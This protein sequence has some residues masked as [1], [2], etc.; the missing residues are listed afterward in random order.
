[1]DSAGRYNPISPLLPP[2]GFATH[3]SFI[4]AF[5][6]NIAKHL[7]LDHVFNHLDSHPTLS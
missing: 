2:S 3:L 6:L 4:P 1:M 5:N 7:A